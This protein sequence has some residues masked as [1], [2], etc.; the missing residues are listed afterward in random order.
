MQNA[1]QGVHRVDALASRTAFH[2]M[3]NAD[4]HRV[5]RG[6]LCCK[7]STQA[8]DVEVNDLR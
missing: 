4:V 2:V 7:C 1:Q 6:E 8:G 5:N 3:Q